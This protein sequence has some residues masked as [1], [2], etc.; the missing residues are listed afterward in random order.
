MRASDKILHDALAKIGLA[1]MAMRAGMGEW[2]DYFGKSPFPQHALIEE[3][4][5]VR[6]QRP[7]IGE[8]IEGVIGLTIEG[9]FDGTREESEA[10]AKS[11]EGV[12][13]LGAFGVE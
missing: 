7:E 12:A 5:A 10:W 9:A 1:D 11:P 4:R 3:L 6:E 13:T 8:L 2:N